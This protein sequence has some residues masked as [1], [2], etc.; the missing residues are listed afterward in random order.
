MDAKT[1]ATQ[2][3]VPCHSG[4][5]SLTP[6]QVSPY[7]AALPEWTVENDLKVK[8]AYRFKDFA[9]ALAFVNRIG[10]VAD[11]QDHHPDLWLA[12]GLVEV[13]IWTHAAMG[14]SENDFILAAKIDELAAGAPGLRKAG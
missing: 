10:A 5:P 3:C 7:A 4:M 9:T 1:L 8:R 2:T 6:E 13:T 14:L 11:E 12:W